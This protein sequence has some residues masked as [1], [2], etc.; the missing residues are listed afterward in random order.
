MN[1]LPSLR[2]DIA[3][4]TKHVSNN[5]FDAS[6]AAAEKVGASWFN[7]DWN[8]CLESSSRIKDYCYQ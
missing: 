3:A 5:A 2:E 1:D 4:L 7:S 6:N 8:C